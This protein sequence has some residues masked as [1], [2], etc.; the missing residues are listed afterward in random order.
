MLNRWIGLVESRLVR[1][2]ELSEMSSDEF[3]LSWI[4]KKT[5]TGRPATNPFNTSCHM[6]DQFLSVRR[7]TMTVDLKVVSKR[8]RNKATLTL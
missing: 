5:I 7:D 6:G 8:M 3:C 1:R 2:G 4:K